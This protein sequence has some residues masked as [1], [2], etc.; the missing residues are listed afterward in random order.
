MW[1]AA[2]GGQA[3]E[4]VLEEKTGAVCRQR[5]RAGWLI[6]LNICLSTEHTCRYVVSRQELW[7]KKGV[8]CKKQLCLAAWR[9]CLIAD[10]AVKWVRETWSACYSSTGGE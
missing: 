4:I 6:L 9:M 3:T 10:A 2:S 5:R 7:Y 1:A 8:G